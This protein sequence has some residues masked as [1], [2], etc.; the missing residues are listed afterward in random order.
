MSLEDGLTRGT[1]VNHPCL[2][3]LVLQVQHRFAHLSG[4]GVFGF[5]AL[6]EHDLR[7]RQLRRKNLFSARGWEQAE[8]TTQPPPTT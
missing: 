4:A 5:V 7:E 2:R 1:G 6:V 8:N 3:Q